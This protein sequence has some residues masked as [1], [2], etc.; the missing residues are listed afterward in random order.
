MLLAPVVT[1]FIISFVSLKAS[2]VTFA[3]WATITVW[4]EYWLFISV[5]KGI[6]ALG[7]SNQRRVSRRLPNDPEESSSSEERRSL[8]S[9]DRNNT[10]SHET[11]WWKKLV[12]RI[13]NGPSLVPW[14]IYLQQD[15]IL[16]GIALAL[17][18]FTVLR[19]VSLDSSWYK[20]LLTYLS[21][22]CLPK[23]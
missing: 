22:C 16:P 1:G 23:V 2:A 15:V 18:F 3:C 8:L 17:L 7:E 4:V 19:C 21:S 14:K 20:I 10:D 11:S 12:R 5:F 6:P 13:S 9:L